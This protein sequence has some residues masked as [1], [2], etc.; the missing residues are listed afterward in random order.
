MKNVMMRFLAILLAFQGF[1]AAQLL[2]IEPAHASTAPDVVINEVMWTGTTVSANDKWI[3]LY[4]PNGY[5]V[6][7]NGLELIANAG[8][9]TQWTVEI[10]EGTEIAP[11]ATLLV[12]NRHTSPTARTAVP[13]I[14]LTTNDSWISVDCATANIRL[15]DESTMEMDSVDCDSGGDYFFPESSSIE[16]ALER[17]MDVYAN[18]A[19]G[20]FARSNQTEGFAGL[21]EA[22]VTAGT[23]GTPGTPNDVT[24][25]DATS[26]VVNDGVSA[27]IDWTESLTEVSANWSGFADPESGLSGDY[28]VEL[29]DST[30]VVIDSATVVGTSH[31]FSSLSLTEGETYRFAVS[32]MNGVNLESLAA[33]SDGITVDTANPEPASNPTVSDVPSDNGG[34]VLVQW[35]ASVSTDEITY[36]VDYNKVGDATVL[37]QDASNLL[38]T[39]I[40]SLENGPVVYEFAVVAIDF[41]GRESLVNPIVQGS[42]LDNLAPVFDV[43][44]LTVA[45]NKPGNSDMV[46][47]AAGASTEAATVT[48]FDRHP[49]DPVAMV[50]ASVQVN[51]S[52][53]FD[54]VSIGDNKHA[55]VWLQLV[56]AGGNSSNIVNVA[57]DIVGPTAPTITSGKATCKTNSCRI[58]L[59]W[60]AVPEATEYVVEYGSGVDLVRTA[61]IANT[62]LILDLPVDGSHNGFVVYALDQF[63]NP[64]AKSNSFSASLVAGV[65]TKGQLHD[66][67]LAVTTAAVE[68]SKETIQSPAPTVPAKIVPTAQAADEDVAV[69]VAGQ[70]DWLRIVIVVVLLLI[71]AGGFYSLSRSMQNSSLDIPP[72]KPT[73]AQKAAPAK[74]RKGKGKKRRSARR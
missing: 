12:A 57:N 3:E 29:L 44:K 2:M 58:E 24:P 32:A 13:D 37:S 48:V 71:V 33:D 11:G 8:V 1:V 22:S 31:T 14:Q 72:T 73:A 63:G 21:T 45:Q 25:A 68:G 55:T 47:G 70:Q 30:D 66:G 10:P 46:S 52:F 26:A 59:Q 19:S 39:T 35:D 41:S 7:A 50:L 51:A 49:T 60:N 56:D 69:E 27:D 9:A 5:T 23:L 6:Q 43:T 65:V 42:A 34:S 36:R 64:S 40:G 54:A 28:N 74:A 38:E 18:D 15:L 67:E 20:W 17:K 61:P 16:H 4:S 62:T 53:G